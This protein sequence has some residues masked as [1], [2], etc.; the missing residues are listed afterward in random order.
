MTT[1]NLNNGVVIPAL[2]IGTWQSPP[3]A[4]ANIVE[5]ALVNAGYRHIDAASAYGNEAEV[6]Q[7][8][9]AAIASGTITRAEIFVTTKVWC[10]YHSRVAESLA[11]SLERL[12]L[13]Y[14]DLLLIHWPV[15]LNPNGNHPITPTL[16]SGDRDID[17]SGSL[18][19]TWRQFE[20]IYKTTRKVRAVGV[21]NC[22]MPYL[23]NLLAE[24]EI[25]PAVNQIELH[26]LLPQIELVKFCR[27][28]SIICE[29]FSPL[30]SSGGPLLKMKSVLDL[31][32]KYN[33]SPSSILLSYHVSDGKVVIAKTV[34]PKRALSNTNL[35]SLSR[36]DI[37][38]LHNCEQAEG[39]HR[40]SKPK[41]GVDLEFPD[42]RD[43]KVQNNS[44]W[45]LKADS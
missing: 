43:W 38:L 20:H 11:L 35:I 30:G 10:T 23:K 41:W 25:V 4:V 17:P 24:A 31:A 19:K 21:C 1:F 3:G 26:P 16:P 9:A 45:V 34:S 7:G 6:G 39:T 33:T 2:A 28:H 40:Y 32:E 14:I 12:G 36:E 42:W 44:A 27:S 13:D 22:S 29:A 37:E 18:I 15:S 8:I 5:Y